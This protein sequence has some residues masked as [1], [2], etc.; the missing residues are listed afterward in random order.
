LTPHSNKPMVA[1]V[2][3]TDIAITAIVVIIPSTAIK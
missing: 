1:S 2:V 3:N